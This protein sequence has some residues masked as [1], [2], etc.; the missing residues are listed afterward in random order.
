MTKDPHAIRLLIGLTG[1]TLVTVVALI[2]SLP[3]SAQE[4]DPIADQIL[5]PGGSG[6]G[7]SGRLAINIAA[8]NN[9]QQIGDAAL[10]IGD[11]A[12]VNQMVLQRFDGAPATDRATEIILEDG[13]FSGVNGLTSISIAAGSQNQMANLA[14]LAIGTSGVLSDQLLEQSRAPVEPRGAAESGSLPSNDRITIGE[15]ALADGSGLIQV[16]L[17]GGEDNSSANTFALSITSE[18]SP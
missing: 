13:A 3:L 15:T 2:M 18:G 11:I 5:V 7:S 10:A 12:I 9:N 4:I 16:N 8:G 17:V 14:L 1:S 6:A